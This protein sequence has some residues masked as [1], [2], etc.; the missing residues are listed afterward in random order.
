MELPEVEV[1]ELEGVDDMLDN[2]GIG[3]R[4]VSGQVVDGNETIGGEGGSLMDFPP[5]FTYK[6]WPENFS[7]VES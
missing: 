3:R 7:T 6:N 4:F 1:D 5:L 2:E